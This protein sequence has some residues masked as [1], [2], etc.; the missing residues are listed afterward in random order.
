MLSRRSIVLSVVG[1]AVLI[2]L[3]VTGGDFDRPGWTKAPPPPIPNQTAQ[4]LE[5]SGVFPGEHHDWANTR[6][7]NTTDEPAIITQIELI[8]GGPSKNLM[9]DPEF[10]ALGVD[11]AFGDGDHL[12]PS[13]KRWWG[14]TPVPAVGYEVPGKDV[15][16]RGMGVN[17]MVRLGVGEYDDVSFKGLRVLYEWKGHEYE[18][19]SNSGI[20]FCRAHH[21]PGKG[22]VLA[23]LCRQEMRH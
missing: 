17:I 18:F 14:V 12:A 2:P 10:F 9:P 22:G 19:T 13:G 23:P 21:V 7:H 6:L 20:L 16:T 11:R 3:C 1:A 4:T 8:P 15:D 5:T